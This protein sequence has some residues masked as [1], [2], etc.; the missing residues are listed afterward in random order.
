MKTRV[1]LVRYP[2][3]ERFMKRCLSLAEKGKGHVSPNPMVG[4]V[5]VKGNRIVGEGYHRLFGGPHAE[6]EAIRSAGKRASGSTLYVNLEPCNHF[7][8]TPPCTKLLIKSGI[9]EVVIAM[10]D[11][12]PQVSGKGLRVLKNAGL[13]VVEGVLEA[14]ARSL[15]E[16]FTK[17]ITTGIPYVTIKVA[18]SL[19]GK[20]ANSRG[21]SKWI[22]NK[23][24]RKHVH[25]LRSEYDAVLVGAKT[26]ISDNP[27]LTSRIPGGRNPIRI[28]LD[29]KLRISRNANIFSI[30]LPARTIVITSTTSVRE[31]NKKIRELERRNVE[32]LSL[33]ANRDQQISL[34][35]AL[36]ALGKCDIASILV[37]GGSQT[38]SA[39]IRNSLADKALIFVAPRI[40]GRGLAAFD[41]FALAAIERQVRSNGFR[42]M[43]FGEDLL[44]DA[45]LHS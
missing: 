9:S 22:S 25:L 20:I 28:I 6:V 39:F 8:K 26:V 40:L 7:G 23:L 33:P 2:A 45:R 21:E 15:N 32:I 34:K 24:S 10:R 18:Q 41:S 42:L 38:F 16:H 29:G 19:D 43:M 36:R 3:R 12:N 5:L 44:I 31:K 13:N 35:R 14:E 4:A 30:P 1:S 17:Y 27:L 11:P 37:E